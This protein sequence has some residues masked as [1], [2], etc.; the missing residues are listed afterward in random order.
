M[1][2]WCDTGALSVSC[3]LLVGGRCF[4]EMFWA[5]GIELDPDEAPATL[6]SLELSNQVGCYN[7]VH[8]DAR[9]TP[10]MGRLGHQGWLLGFGTRDCLQTAR[11]LL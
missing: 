11:S 2:L 1:Q 4:L 3:G 6:S 8:M 5:A 9:V 10:W 7:A